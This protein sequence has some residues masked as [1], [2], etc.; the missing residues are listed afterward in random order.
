MTA[1]GLDEAMQ[2]EAELYGN[3]RECMESFSS[4]TEVLGQEDD[5]H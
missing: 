5:A 2:I 1:L 3:G 4:C